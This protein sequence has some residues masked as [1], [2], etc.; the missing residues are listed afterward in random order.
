MQAED[1][2]VPTGTADVDQQRSK[3][4]LLR[5][6]ERPRMLRSPMKLRGFGRVPGEPK[7]SQREGLRGIDYAFELAV[8]RRGAGPKRRP[9]L[10]ECAQRAFQTRTVD[11]AI[12]VESHRGA[13]RTGMQLVQE[14]QMLQ[15][16]TRQE[17]PPEMGIK[18]RRCSL[19][20]ARFAGALNGPRRAMVS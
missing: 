16:T 3:R 10:E 11:V 7:S 19:Q 6:P 5:K 13:A 2:N 15:R 18:A 14:P 17:F 4:Q 12:Q 1:Q 9:P 20:Q 8:R